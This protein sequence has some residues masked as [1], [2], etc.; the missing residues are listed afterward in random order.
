MHLSLFFF[1]NNLMSSGATGSKVQP[2]MFK[3]RGIRI[4]SEDF[5]VTDTVIKS[6]SVISCAAHFSIARARGDL[7]EGANGF[8][9][10]AEERKCLIGKVSF[11]LQ[12]VENKGIKVH[13]ISKFKFIFNGKRMQL[14]NHYE[15]L[16]HIFFNV[17]HFFS[18]YFFIP[19]NSK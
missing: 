9:F 10:D 4:V 12:E 18:E 11:P 8:H 19:T 1:F 3:A 7:A 2:D 5:E 6:K 17:C 13:G 16:V 15:Q 14:Q